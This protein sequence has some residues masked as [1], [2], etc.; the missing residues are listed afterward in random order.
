MGRTITEKPKNPGS[1]IE[2]LD[3]V[4]GI[5]S[6]MVLV[7]HFYGI[8][9]VAERVPYLVKYWPVPLGMVLNPH[10]AVLIFFVLSGYVLAPPF[11]NGTQPA[12]PRYLLKRFCRI[13]IPFALCLIVMMP[14]GP[15]VS[16]LAGHFLLFGTHPAMSQNPAI[17]TLVYELRIS[18]IFP[19][20]VLLCRNTYIALFTGTCMFAAATAALAATGGGGQAR[21]TPPPLARRFSG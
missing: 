12:Y 7:A 19:L 5:A 1:R 18:V 9:P 8:W 6:V 4:R 2:T 10:A 20:L 14:P 17:W 13:Y 3:S 16:L 21:S 11:F 15:S